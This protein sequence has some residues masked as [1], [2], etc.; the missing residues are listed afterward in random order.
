MSPS[1]RVR[2][3]A[4]PRAGRHFSHTAPHEGIGAWGLLFPGAKDQVGARL[5]LPWVPLCTG[6]RLARGAAFWCQDVSARA[7]NSRVLHR[8][9]SAASKGA[10][11]KGLSL[12]GFLRAPLRD[13][14]LLFTSCSE[15]GI[16]S[17]ADVSCLTKSGLN[18]LCLLAFPGWVRRS[19]DPSARPFP[20]LAFPRSLEVGTTTD[21]SIPS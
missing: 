13:V 15:D 6:I 5:S 1:C 12:P 19:P 7:D 11:F 10:A 20:G 8:S 16:T 2:Q 9:L 4:A 21:G 3:A 17:F 14:F 18:A